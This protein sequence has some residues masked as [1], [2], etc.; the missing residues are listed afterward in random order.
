MA[1]RTEALDALLA[2][3][4]Q[5]EAPH[6]GRRFATGGGEPSHFE[7]FVDVYEGLERAKGWRPTRHVPLNPTT[8]DGGRRG[9]RT[10]IESKTSRAWADL[11]NLRYRMALSW[12]SHVFRLAADAAGPGRSLRGLVVH[13]VFGEMYAMKAVAQVLMRSPLTDDRDDPRR[14]GPPFE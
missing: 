4:A 2:I 12:L 10:L 9:K 5:G 11:F 14:A 8:R 6:L 7:R 13:R 1:T 3:A